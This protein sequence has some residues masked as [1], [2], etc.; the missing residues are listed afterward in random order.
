M[1][2]VNLP[3]GWKQFGE[4]RRWRCVSPSWYCEVDQENNTPSFLNLNSSVNIVKKV[5]AFYS[6]KVFKSM[7]D[8]HGNLVDLL[9]ANA[10]TESYGTVPTPFSKEELTTVLQTCGES[11]VHLALASLVDYIKQKSK[12][13]VRKEPGYSDPLS[14]PDRISVG[15]HHVL[16][17]TAVET[18]NLP[19][20]T[21]KNKIDTITGLIIDLA[22]S[23]V[24]A[25]E[26]ALS[27][28]Q[29]RYSKHL[30]EPPL[31]AAIYNAGSLMPSSKNPWN[32]CSIR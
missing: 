1:S 18:L 9:T 30:L 24:Y 10:M 6:G 3:N 27:Y 22:S 5:R 32:L 19:F 20:S 23:S 13:L 8:E 26:M 17:S 16:L 2:L 14:T 31:M 12:N 25:A 28:F 29:K 4:G 11:D 15:A 21:E 7:P